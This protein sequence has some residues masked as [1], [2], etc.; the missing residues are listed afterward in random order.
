VTADDLDGA[1]DRTGLGRRFLAVE[2]IDGSGKTTQAGLLVER[3]RRSGREVVACR[4]PGST[5][6][7]DAIRE[8]LLHRRDLAVD[9]TAEMLLYM[10]ARAQLV[11]EVIVPALAR[12]AWVVSDRFLL[13]NIVYQGYAGGLDPDAVR[14]VGR[15]ATGGLAPAI[16]LVF[17]VDPETAASRLRGRSDGPLDKLEVRGDGY[18]RKVLHGFRLEAQR[19]PDAVRLVDASG[20]PEAVADRAFSILRS[21]LECSAAPD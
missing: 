4:D 7:G 11:S 9:R 2:G 18:R 21:W 3:L 1:Q 15:V 19:R 10:A 6:T 14:N 13:S 8:I 17:D 12:G 20:P 5:P 16:T